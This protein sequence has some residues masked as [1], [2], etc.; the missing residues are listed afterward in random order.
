MPEIRKLTDSTTALERVLVEFTTE[1][2]HASAD[3]SWAKKMVKISST[4]M[5]L[6]LIAAGFG[7]AYGVDARATAQDIIDVRAE[8]RIAACVQDNK[9][10]EGQRI[11]ISGVFL[12]FAHPNADGSLTPTELDIYTKIEQRVETLLPFRDCSPEGI[13][14]YYA[15]PPASDPATET[16]R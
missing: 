6:A 4:G 11:A 16:S 12:V 5:V 3:S 1:L 8:T 10:I 13:T 9:A 14:A 2:K 7:I 15:E